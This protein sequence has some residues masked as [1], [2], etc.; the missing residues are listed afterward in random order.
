MLPIFS[1]RSAA[2]PL[3]TDAVMDFKM[4]TEVQTSV[5]ELPDT[6]VRGPRA[7][8]AGPVQESP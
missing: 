5:E 8:F 7:R 6:H 3:R 1:D 2:S 4:T